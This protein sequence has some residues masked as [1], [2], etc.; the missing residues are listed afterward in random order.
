MSP[1]EHT[2]FKNWYGSSSAME[3]DW[4]VEGFRAAEVM[5]GLRYT[6]VIGDVDSSNIQT[7]GCT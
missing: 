4:L 5:H 1:K 6:H 3:S 2:C 7:G